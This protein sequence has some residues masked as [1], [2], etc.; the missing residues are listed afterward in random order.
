MPL[1][2]ASPTR[3]PLADVT[4]ALVCNEQATWFR[5]ASSKSEA[6]GRRLPFRAREAFVFGHRFDAGFAITLPHTGSEVLPHQRL[7]QCA[8]GEL[9]LLRRRH[10]Q[11]RQPVGEGLRH[12]RGRYAVCQPRQAQLDRKVHRRR[13]VRGDQVF[14]SRH[15]F[16]VALPG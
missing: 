11:V 7:L 12:R 16:I 13:L 4:P 1:D 8:G 10:R 9:G 15:V 6:E 2:D 14:G 3:V 5:I